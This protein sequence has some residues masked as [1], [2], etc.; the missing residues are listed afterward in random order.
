MGK[1]GRGFSN[2]FSFEA[3]IGKVKVRAMGA[4]ILWCLGHLWHAAW[5]LISEQWTESGAYM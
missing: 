1:V 2:A 5:L 4:L 3:G